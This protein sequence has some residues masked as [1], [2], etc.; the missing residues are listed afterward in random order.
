MKFKF[1]QIFMLMTA[2]LLLVAGSTDAFAEGPVSTEDMKVFSWRHIGPWN[3]SGRITDFAIPPGQSQVYYVATASGGL[4]KTED[5]GISFVSLFDKLR[6]M[7]KLFNRNRSSCGTD[8]P[9]F[10]MDF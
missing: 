9:V 5:C 10:I 7:Q 4:W 3:F 6:V 1:K 8:V 2:V